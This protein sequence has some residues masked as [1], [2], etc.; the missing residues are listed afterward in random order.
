M[1]SFGKMKLQYNIQLKGAHHDSI[2]FTLE[3]GFL[4]GLFPKGHE[5]AFGELMLLE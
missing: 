4:V 2:N 5:E 1:L 3:H